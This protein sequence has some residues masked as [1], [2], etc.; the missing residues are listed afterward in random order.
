MCA[1][2]FVCVC[3]CVC[4]F[5]WGK[6]CVCKLYNICTVPTI[7]CTCTRHTYMVSVWRNECLFMNKQRRAQNV[8]IGINVN[9]VHIHKSGSKHASNLKNVS[10]GGGQL[11]CAHELKDTTSWTTPHTITKLNLLYKD[12]ST[13]NSMYFSVVLVKNTTQKCWHSILIVN[14]VSVIVSVLWSLML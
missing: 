8:L 11:E 9:V 1:C 10:Q 6:W 12:T 13:W 7:T 5:V 3:L 14:E 2:V 4:V